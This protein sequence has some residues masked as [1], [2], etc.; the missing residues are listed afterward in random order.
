GQIFTARARGFKSVLEM[1][2]SDP[3]LPVSVY[4]SLIATARANLQLLQRYLELR[5]QLLGVDKLGMYDLYVPLIA[6]FDKEVSFDEAK[7]TAI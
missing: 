1:K 6:G 4:D 3:R 2:L 5:R 7:R